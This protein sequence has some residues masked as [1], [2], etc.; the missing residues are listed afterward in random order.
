MTGSRFFD[1]PRPTIQPMSLRLP[2]GLSPSKVES[3][4]SCPLAFRFS[5]IDRVPEPPSVAASKG[6]LV[7]RAL[8]LLHLEEPSDRTLAMGLAALDRAATELHDHP[9]FTGL[10]LDD[11]GERDLLD[12][13][14]GLVRRYFEL[15]DPTKVRAI[16][17]ELRLEAKLGS[18][19]L[20][21]II[22]RLELDDDGELVITDYKTGRTPHVNHE[23]GRLGGVHFYAYLCQQLFGRRPARVQLLYLAEP[24][25]IIA[26]P[27]EQSIRFL[28]KKAAAIWQA[29]ELACSS[30]DFRPRTGPLCNYCFYKTWCPA[31]GGDPALAV[32]EA[33][34]M[35][36]SL[37]TSAA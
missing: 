36:R 26:T 11:A 18:L 30:E 34:A 23:G 20:R 37:A 14:E 1:H 6:T 2:T 10:H 19:V 13:A 32:V 28:P 7:H 35:M 12:A 15:E 9:D 25:A 29:V 31:Y 33:E 8:E 3:F 17:L 21:G 24:V 4:K 22:D 5:A 16:G 27:S